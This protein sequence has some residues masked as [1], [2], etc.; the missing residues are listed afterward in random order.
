MTL[1]FCVGKK[2]DIH[3]VFPEKIMGDGRWHGRLWSV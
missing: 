2:C 3:F 1:L